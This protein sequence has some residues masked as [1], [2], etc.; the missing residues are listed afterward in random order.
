MPS[1]MMSVLASK[2][3]MKGRSPSG[4]PPSPAPKV[5]PGVVRRASARVDTARSCIR[6]SVMMVTDFGVS[7]SGAVN[8]TESDVSRLYPGLCSPLT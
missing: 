4:V 2:P 6:D 5:I 7:R 8:F 1:I 3:R